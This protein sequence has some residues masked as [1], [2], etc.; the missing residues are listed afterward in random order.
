MAWW[1]HWFL[2]HYWCTY[3]F[4]FK[5]TSIPSRPLS[6]IIWLVNTYSKLNSHS[7]Y[8]ASPRFIRKLF[9]MFKQVINFLLLHI[10]DYTLVRD[11]YRAQE[12]PEV[13]TW[14]YWTYSVLNI[15]LQG[16]RFSLWFLNQTPLT[17]W[18]FLACK[19]RHIVCCL[20]LIALL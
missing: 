10:W 15:D 17:N 2:E 3:W 4:F 16:W 19:L 18:V 9:K 5:I 1:Q 20:Y 6:D 12:I 11:G 14:S 8:S 7:N 13:Q